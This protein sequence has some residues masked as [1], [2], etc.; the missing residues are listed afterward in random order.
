MA[1]ILLPGL[2]RG[3]DRPILRLGILPFGTVAWEAETIRRAKLDEAAGY[4]LETLRL[5]NNDAARVAFQAGQVDLIVSDLL[6]AA[7]LRNEG[8]ALKFLPF[9]ATEGA[10]MVRPDSAVHSVGDLKGKRIGV[11][12]GALDKSWLLLNAYVQERAGFDLKADAMPAYG[13]P[14]LLNSKLETGELDAALLYWQFCARLE[15]KGFRRLIGAGEIT[16]AFGLDGEIALLGYIFDEALADR[17]PDLVEGFA[18]SS[19]RAKHILS[20]SDE[21]WA[22]IRPMME[23]E[24]DATFRV[25]KRYFIE[26]IPR[27]PIEVERAD[28]ERLYAVLSR[29]GGEKLVGAGSE[30]PDNLYWGET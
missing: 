10:L 2:A 22:A 17:S 13:A 4:R 5:A 3:Q 12:G 18:A 25:L 7:R 14:P 8:R 15:A 9:S 26:G 11:A 29:L 16:R 27:R 30:L 6:L 20:T 23:A 24:D 21:A 28:A 19:R 1:G